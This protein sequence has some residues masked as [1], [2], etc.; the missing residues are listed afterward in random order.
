MT[1]NGR[2]TLNSV[3]AP[4]RLASENATFENNRVKTNK[5]RPILSVSEISQ[6]VYSFWQY[7]A[8][9]DIRAGSFEMGFSISV[10]ASS[11]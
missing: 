1:L 4:E 9:A 10:S 11:I 2:F 8:C 3:F 5:D 7:K 6:K